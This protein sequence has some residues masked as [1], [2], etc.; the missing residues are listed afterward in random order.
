MARMRSELRCLQRQLHFST[1]LDATAVQRP[2]DYPANVL[3]R[4]TQLF[5]L[6]AQAFCLDTFFVL[7]KEVDESIFD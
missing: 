3:T 2:A 7:T 1:K 5:E 6:F 4:V